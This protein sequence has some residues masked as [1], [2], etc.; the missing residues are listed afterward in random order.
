MKRFF[1]DSFGVDHKVSKQRVKVICLDLTKE[2]HQDLVGQ[3]PLSGMCLWDHFGIP[4]GT[5]SRARFRRLS[6]RIH[7]PPTLQTPKFPDGIPGLKGLHA[8]KLRASIRLYNYM[9]RLIKQLQAAN[10]IW[11]VENPLTSLLWETS[12]WNS[13]DKIT[14]PVY[15]ELHNCIKAHMSGVQQ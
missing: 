5:A 13:I 9:R 6:R 8:V 11:T 1:P 7:G 3:W 14:D 12:Y 15:C 4:C 10:V 2:D